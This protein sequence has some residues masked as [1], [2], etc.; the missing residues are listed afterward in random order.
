M[1]SYFLTDSGFLDSSNIL[2]G[3]SKNK[4]RDFFIGYLEESKTAFFHIFTVVFLLF[5]RPFSNP[6]SNV[7]K[8]LNI[9]LGLKNI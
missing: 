6:F 2:Q 1:D 4:L 8:N 3:L 5:L 9:Y 7:V